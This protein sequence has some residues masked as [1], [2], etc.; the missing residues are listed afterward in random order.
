MTM[1]KTALAVMLLFAATCVRGAD[2]VPY[3]PETSCESHLR[4]GCPQTIA[5]WARPTNTPNYSGYYVGGGAALD[6]CGRCAR[7]GTWG[8]DYTGV[9]PKFVALN[10]WHGARRQGGGGAYATDH[11]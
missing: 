10:W 7:E 6:G 1:R 3:Q 11:K 5:S 8:W 2:E 9:I 4:A